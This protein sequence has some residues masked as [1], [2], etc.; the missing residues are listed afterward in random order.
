MVPVQSDFQYIPPLITSK[1]KIKP[2][3]PKAKNKRMVAKSRYGKE[4]NSYKKGYIDMR[5]HP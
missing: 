5:S 2:K 4:K 3:Y 1:K